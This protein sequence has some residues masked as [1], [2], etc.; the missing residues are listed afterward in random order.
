METIFVGDLEAFKGE[1]SLKEEVLHATGARLAAC[2]ST[3]SCLK[4]LPGDAEPSNEELS[5]CQTEHLS[6]LFPAR[7]LTILLAGKKQLPALTF[8]WSPLGPQAL[9]P[10][11]LL[12]GNEFSWCQEHSA[13]FPSL[14]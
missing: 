8:Q 12:Q 9:S 6:H 4:P 11:C 14:A 3:P 7:G 13:I 1:A 10:P 2:C 5:G